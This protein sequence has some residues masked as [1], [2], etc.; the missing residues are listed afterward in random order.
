MKFLT[1]NIQHGRDYIKKIIDLKNLSDKIKDID[2]DIIILNEV[3]GEGS[4]EMF[5]DEPKILAN[6]LHMNYFFGKAITISK[7]NYGNAILSK[8]EIKNPEVFRIEDPKVHD[9]DTYY[10]SRIIIKAEINGFICLGTHLGLANSERLN[11]INKL[12]ELINSYQ[13]NVVVMGDFNMIPDN[14][15]LTPLKNIC[16]DVT[17]DLNPIDFLSFPSI[18]PVEKIDYIFIS[19]DLTSS[20]LIVYNIVVYDYLLH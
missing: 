9:E 11:G 12:V 8:Y 2:P 20:N 10:E 7:G 5:G 15:L 6:Y 17:K 13:N 4:L 19:K 14:P 1:F 18:D 16:D 3:F